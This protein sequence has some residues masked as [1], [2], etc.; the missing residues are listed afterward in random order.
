MLGMIAICVAALVCVLLAPA[1]R[2]ELYHFGAPVG[3]STDPHAPASR[4]WA[5]GLVRLLRLRVDPDSRLGRDLVMAQ[6]PMS[7]ADL[8][9][10][11][12][13]LPLAIAGIVLLGMV[14]GEIRVMRIVQLLSVPLWWRVPD[15]FVSAAADRVRRQIQ[16]AIPSFLMSLAISTEAG[17]NLFPAIQEYARRGAGPLPEQ[18][19]K[20]LTEAELGASHAHAL[21]RMA[22]RCEVPELHSAVS[23]LV[24]AVEHGAAGLAN[25]VRDQARTAANKRRDAARELAQKASMKLFFPLMFLVMPTLMLFLLGP[26]VYSLWRDF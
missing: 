23:A 18:L 6:M 3:D 11:K 4:R 17:M 26:A 22:D 20:A 19:R 25:V 16:H 21:I 9:V 7:L 1:A 2:T 5:A 24:Q 8:V 15:I 12:V 14:G 13:L 10:A